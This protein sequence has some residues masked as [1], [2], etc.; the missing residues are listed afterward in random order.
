MTQPYITEGTIRFIIFFQCN[1]FC[2]GLHRPD[3]RSPSSIELH[4][5]SKVRQLNCR[6][7]HG[8]EINSEDLRNSVFLQYHSMDS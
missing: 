2:Q 7:G 6:P 3:I 8:Q 5:V 4:H 1:C